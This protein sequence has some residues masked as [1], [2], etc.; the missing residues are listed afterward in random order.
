MT[1]DYHD[2]IDRREA[3]ERAHR[4]E[5]ELELDEKARTLCPHPIEAAVVD[6][7]GALRVV[8]GNIYD[9]R[10]ERIICTKCGEELP[11]V[12]GSVEWFEQIQEIQF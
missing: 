2:T 6:V 7:T 9:D 3:R 11:P 12:L 10:R 1:A 4:E 5:I 8:G